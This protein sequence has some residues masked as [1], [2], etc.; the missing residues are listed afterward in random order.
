MQCT[1]F[2]FAVDALT[3]AKQQG[4]APKTCQTHQRVDNAAEDGILTAEQPSYQIKL[5][6]A[7][8]TPVQTADNGKNQCQS[9]HMCTSIS[10]IWLPIESPGVDKNIHPLE[11]AIQIIY[12]DKKSMEVFL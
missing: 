3:L 6:N 5:E 1:R 10:V 8:Q 2:L 7:N 4:N 11:K 9:I 12:N